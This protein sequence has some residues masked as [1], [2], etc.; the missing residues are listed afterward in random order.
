[1]K[2][3]QAKGWNRRLALGAGA[4]ALGVGAYWLSGK[5]KPTLHEVTPEGVFH[6]GNGAEPGTLDPTQFQTEPEQNVME[7]LFIGLTTSDP[8][9][10]PIPGMAASWTTSDDGLIWT[11]KLRQAQWSD[12]TPLTADDFVFAWRRL[13][14]PK[15]AAPYGYF[16]D[17]VKNSK[18]INSGKLPP[19]ELGVAAPDPHTFIITLAHPA[20]YLVEM[21][22]HMS[23]YPLPR[24]VVEAKGKDWSKPG[25]HVCN[26]PFMLTEWVPNDHITLV[27][28]PR[29]YDA[30]KVA[31]N[32]VI[33]YPTDDYAAALKQMRAGSIDTQTRIPPEQI[34]WVKAN[35]PQ[36][37][38]PIAQLTTE[39]ISVNLKR[40]PFDDIRVRAA[41]NMAVNREAITEK[42]RRVG[43]TPAYNIVPP[44][45]VNFPGG[46]VVD[47]KALS[48]QQRLEKARG[49]M[50]EAGFGP[51]NRLRTTFMIRSTAAGIYRAC[52]AAV[53]QMFAQI[54]VDISIL[55][56][57][58]AIFENLIT[59]PVCDYDI[60]ECAWSGDFND[61][62]SY[63]TLFQTGGG[64]NWAQYS[65]P[66]FDAMLVEEQKVVD[67]Q[68]RGAL[69]A[70]AEAKLLQDHATIPLFFWVCPNMT[71]PYVKGW[72]PN[73]I[74]YHCSR[75]VTID[76]KARAA[77]SV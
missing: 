41:L 45:V 35:M 67:I 13:V 57:D 75:W 56:T 40:K 12:G 22:T 10:N 28:N 68:E 5:D 39:F 11:F 62:E 4:A 25:N 33:F 52:A 61:A 49:L 59:P 14:D 6:R 69:L 16:L 43:D 51:D 17:A 58:F 64:N 74:D 26:G 42:I 65:D 77:S 54:Y 34:D 31:L 32:K 76:Q 1:M 7:D 46:N 55:P 27:K 15:S 23:L 21:L 20:P 36:V 53:Q 73:A 66:D 63:L 3:R 30:D 72:V 71:Q 47:F 44:G 8:T 2:G 19:A 29:F 37:L 50:R 70:K 18:A 38:T 24:H 48:P 60:C 9:A